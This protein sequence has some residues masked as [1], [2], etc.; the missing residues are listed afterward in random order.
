[1]RKEAVPEAQKVMNEIKDDIR[2]RG[3]EM[4]QKST[5]FEDKLRKRKRYRK[6]RQIQEFDRK[7]GKKEY[8]PPP[9][10]NFMRKQYQRELKR[11]EEEEALM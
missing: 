10:T 7:H 3:R 8:Q 1:M 5:V 4:M 2:K 6:Y 11:K 9:T